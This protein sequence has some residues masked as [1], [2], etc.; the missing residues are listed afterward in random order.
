MIDITFIIPAYNCSNSISRAVKSI[1][2]NSKNIN[3]EILIVENGST[4][5]SN[6]IIK[7]LAK[8]NKC[9]RVFHSKK[10]VSRARNLGIKNAKGKW[11]FFLDADDYLI[12]NFNKFQNSD[13]IIW[14]YKVGQK[15]RELSS[16]TQ[17]VKSPD[18]IKQAIIYMLN[19]PTKFMT[20]WG[21][22][23]NKEIINKNQLLF[24]ESIEVGE[25]SEFFLQYLLKVKTITFNPDYVYCYSMDDGSTTRSQDVQLIDKYQKSMSVIWN[26]S[27][28]F[29]FDTK[30]AINGYIAINF[31][32]AVVRGIYVQEIGLSD[33]YS[34]MKM[35]AQK[36]PFKDAIN[37][38]TYNKN[39]N[40]KL[41]PMFLIKYHLSWLANIIFQARRLQNKNK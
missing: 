2:V 28:N 23:F 29:S 25:D 20:V 33:K 35:Y 30:Q 8:K 32:V 15:K 14:N 12:D 5:N 22:L 19:D 26:K 17:I 16:T 37:K 36:F 4:D 10:G 24:D 41:M 6:V 7:Q 40:P 34:K 21:K 9:I 1:E 11:L 13:L 38:I 39:K 3:Y 31:I 27:R 18:K